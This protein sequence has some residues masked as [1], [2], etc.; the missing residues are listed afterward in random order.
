VVSTGADS[1]SPWC[2]RETCQRAGGGR[3]NLALP[4]SLRS[5]DPADGRGDGCVPSSLLLWGSTWALACGSSE[6]AEPRSSASFAD[7]SFVHG[8]LHPPPLGCGRAGTTP[9]LHDWPARCRWGWEGALPREGEAGGVA[10]ARAW[11]VGGRLC[12]RGFC[13]WRR[14]P[15]VTGY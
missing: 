2:R 11:G 14:G 1:C 7:N 8:S 13:T 9:R 4:K 3:A 15:S 10:E 12:R 5:A 6:G